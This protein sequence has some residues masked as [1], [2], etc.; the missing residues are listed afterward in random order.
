[1]W[2]AWRLDGFTWAWIVWIVAFIVIETAAVRAGYRG[3][4]TAHLRPLFLWQPWFWWAGL[5]LFV[6]IGVHI[7]T[8][9]LE[10]WILDAVGRG[11]P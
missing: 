7:F 3:T 1:M 6:A 9:S 5:G 10:R 2:S 4:L 11:A 8:P